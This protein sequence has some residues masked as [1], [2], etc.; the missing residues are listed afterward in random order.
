MLKNVFLMSAQKY[1]LA[2]REGKSLW[3]SFFLSNLSGQTFDNVWLMRKK[4]GQFSHPQPKTNLF[5]YI[6]SFQ[7]FVF[8]WSGPWNVGKSPPPQKKSNM[9]IENENYLYFSILY[10]CVS[11]SE[12]KKKKHTIKKDRKE[13]ERKRRKSVKNM[14]RKWRERK[15]NKTKLKT[16]WIS[17]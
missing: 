4:D 6:F 17:W 10:V 12:R 5:K 14:C 11:T 1:I 8:L 13:N 16:K 2:V 9:N 3:E 15:L 7:Q